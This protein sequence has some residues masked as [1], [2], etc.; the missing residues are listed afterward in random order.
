MTV[1]ELI[2]ELQKYPEDMEV[3]KYRYYEAEDKDKEEFDALYDMSI[4]NNTLIID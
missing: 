3:Y 1:K 4:Y 2:E